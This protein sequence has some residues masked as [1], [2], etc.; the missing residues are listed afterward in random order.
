[1]GDSLRDELADFRLRSLARRAG[2]TA[3]PMRLE[4][5]H[6]DDAEGQAYD[7]RAQLLGP[8]PR[9]VAVARLIGRPASEVFALMRQGVSAK[10]IIR[11][12]RP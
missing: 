3:P 8:A 10:E 11:R 5:L 12:H 9:A 7:L 2:R 1:M 4:A 6:G